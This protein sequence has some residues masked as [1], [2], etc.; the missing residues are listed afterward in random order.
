MPEYWKLVN[1]VIHDAD[2]L[3]L[4]LDARLVEDT[5][6]EEIEHKVK[7]AQKPLIYTITKCDLVPREQLEH[8]KKELNPCAIVSAREHLGTTRLRDRI[9]MEAKKLKLDRKI[10]RIGVLGYPNV[11]KSSLINSM[12]G[13]HSA[14]TSIMSGFTKSVQ[15]IRADNR[16]VFLDTPGVIPYREREWIKHALIGTI[17][18]TKARDPEMAIIGLIQKFPGKV[19]SYYH[20]SPHEDI[21]DTIEEVAKKKNILKKGGLPD[22]VRVARMILKDWQKGLIK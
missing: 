2:V 1:Q 20:V 4:L 19:E 6:N 22:V 5:R 21:D 9:L 10:V 3:L 18:F 7:L 16:L 17:D 8:Y 12:K 13:K 15:E 11:G 14:P